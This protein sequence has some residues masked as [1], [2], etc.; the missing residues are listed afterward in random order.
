MWGWAQSREESV[1]EMFRS[2][3]RSVA[4]DDQDPYSHLVLGL[5]HFL[6]G[7]NDHTFAAYE[8]AIQLDPSFVWAYDFLG[9]ALAYAGRTDEAIANLEKAIRLDPEGP[10]K[11]EYLTGM[12]VAHFAAERYEEALEWAK[13]S[14]RWN[15]AYRLVYPILAATCAHLGRDDDARS[16]LDELLRLQPQSS[17]AGRR[18]ALANADPD[19]LERYLDGLRKAGLK[20]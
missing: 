15:P 18:R 11:A 2:A 9:V 8:R 7:Q 4:L 3:Q 10:G 1:A 19:F 12:A 6:R 16:A 14:V 17:L 20:E 13:K 5:S